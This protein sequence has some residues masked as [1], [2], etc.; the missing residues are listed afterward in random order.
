LFFLF[1]PKIFSQKYVYFSAKRVGY[2]ASELIYG[3]MERLSTMVHNG[4]ERFSDL[5]RRNSFNNHYGHHNN[6]RRKPNQYSYQHR[7]SYAY[8]EEP[9]AA[10][11][12]T[13]GYD[14]KFE[15]DY[16]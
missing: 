2:V 6:N 8:D 12:D 7:S 13:S 5:N 16:N 3:P 15:N 1:I 14:Y 10:A 9:A 11:D 4:I